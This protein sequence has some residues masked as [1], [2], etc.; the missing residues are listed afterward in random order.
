M[1]FR[2]RIVPPSTGQIFGM[3]GF[4]VWDGSITRSSDGRYHLFA[5]RWPESLGMR[6]WLT[7][8]RIIRAEAARPTGPYEFVEELTALTSQAWSES[9]VHNPVITR[10][11]DQF[12]LFYIGTR[13]DGADGAAARE[14]NDH[15][16][17]HIRFQQ[18]IGLATASHPAGPWTPCPGNPILQPRP[19]HWD[20]CITVNPSVLELAPGN[21]LMVYKSTAGPREPL[22]LGAATAKVP[23]GPYARVEPSPLFGDDVEDPCMWAE[24]GRYWMLVKDMTGDVGGYRH[25]GLLYVSDDALHWDRAEPVQAYDRVIR[26]QDAPAEEVQFVERPFVY[27]ENGRPHLLCNAI[28]RPG[29][30]A[31]V[32]IRQLH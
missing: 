23:E 5:S 19:D 8:S 7:D 32:L 10:I 31:G 1:N 29:Q 26:W 27:T 15:A 6:A 2:N 21:L 25:G 14:N 4:Y 18:R 16:W 11:G 20:A 3:Q 17:Q 24:N 30:R 13:W 12:C 28:R 9:M 22:I